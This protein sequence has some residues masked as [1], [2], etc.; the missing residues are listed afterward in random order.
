M[1]ELRSA[2]TIANYYQDG[3]SKI[4]MVWSIKRLD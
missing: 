3:R 2:L 4:K 1:E